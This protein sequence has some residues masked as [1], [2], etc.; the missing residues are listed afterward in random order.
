MALSVIDTTVIA[1]KSICIDEAMAD[2][3]VYSDTLNC[4]TVVSMPTSNVTR[5]V[6]NGGL[7]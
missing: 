4:S 2:L 5:D 1:E 3:Y 7:S 6:D